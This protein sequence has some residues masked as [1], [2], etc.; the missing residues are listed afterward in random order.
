M[1]AAVSLEAFVARVDLD[2]VFWGSSRFLLVSRLLLGWLVSLFS[3]ISGYV[4][5]RFLALPSSCAGSCCVVWR[6]REGGGGGVPRRHRG[7]LMAVA[8]VLKIAHPQN[9]GIFACS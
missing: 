2:W 9:Y 6:S 8:A 7:C 1:V 3:V 5:S 4:I